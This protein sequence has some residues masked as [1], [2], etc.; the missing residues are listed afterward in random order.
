MAA[1]CNEDISHT[2]DT[3]IFQIE[4]MTLQP[5]ITVLRRYK[6]ETIDGNSQ[7]RPM[8]FPEVPWDIAGK[9]RI[10]QRP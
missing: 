9:E 5:A 7:F 3:A 2:A 8:L 6:I 10:K 4:N 1:K